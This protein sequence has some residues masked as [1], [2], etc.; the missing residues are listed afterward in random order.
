MA[1]TV[2]KR[3][4]LSLPWVALRGTTRTINSQS[5]NVLQED[6]NGNVLFATGTATITDAASGY[7]KGCLYIDTDVGAGTAALYSNVGTTTSCNFDILEAGPTT[8][9]SNALDNLAA[10]AI[11]TTLVSDTANTDDL[12]S[13]AVPWR[14]AYVGTSL[15]F[16]QTTR[17]LT[18]TASEPATLA[19]TVNFGD[20]GGNDSV[21]YEAATQTLTNKT[22]TIDQLTVGSAAQGDVIFRGAAAFERLAAGSAGQYLK[23]QGAAADPIWDDPGIAKL[24]Q[25][26]DIEAGTNDVTLST[27]TQTVGAA[28]LTIPDFASVADTFTFNTL[29]ATILNKTLD[30]ATCKF[31]DTADATKDLFFS[32]G[33]ATTAKTMT[34]VSSHTDDRSLTL[35]DATD[36]LVGK[37]TTDT[38]TNKILSD[39]TCAFGDNADTTKQAVWSL[40]GATTAKTLTMTSSH[41]DD[42]A[43]TLPDATDTLVGKA[44]TDTLTNK[45]IDAD[46]TGNVISNINGTELDS[47]AATTGTYGI[48]VVI[49]AANAGAADINVFSGVAPFKFRVL[50]A[51]AVNTQAGNAGNWKLQDDGANDIT[52]SVAYGAGDTDITRADEIDDAYHDI[53]TSEELHVINSNAA[54]TSIVYISVLRVD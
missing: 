15:V 9:A 54:D 14:T 5:V 32:L 25:S 18:I 24:A 48:P 41:T 43:I 34:I 17:N 26:Q 21:V 45:T 37:A 4:P 7:A 50:D 27:T 47:V 12:G 49:V 44:T 20:P 33:G 13:D 42:R 3:Q 22:M 23:S 30:D 11:N 29:A 46:G 19:R 52:A 28:T 40:G 16:D 1:R 6:G 35:P 39:S 51:W 2:K 8:G 38:L 36:T 53:T 31:G 10:V